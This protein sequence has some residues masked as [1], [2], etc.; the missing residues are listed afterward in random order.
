LKTS[1]CPVGRLGCRVPCCGVSGSRT[2]SAFSRR[3]LLRWRS[4]CAQFRVNCRSLDLELRRRSPIRRSSLVMRARCGNRKRMQRKN[5]PP[6]FGLV[7]HLSRRRR[8]TRWSRWRV[9][10]PVPRVRSERQ[11]RSAAHRNCAPIRALPA[12]TTAIERDV[13]HAHK[14]KWCVNGTHPTAHPPG[15]PKTRHTHSDVS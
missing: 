1:G 12:T 10:E 8:R 5:H 2:G 13:T 7:A 6:M 15:S 4:A 14:I 11:P 3:R 9:G